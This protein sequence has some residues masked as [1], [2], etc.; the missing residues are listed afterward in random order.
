M[1]SGTSTSV[2]TVGPLLVRVQWDF[3]YSVYSGA[4]TSVCT[5]GPPLV[6]VQ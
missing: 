3:Y 2:C 6:C 4:S 5:V 1:K